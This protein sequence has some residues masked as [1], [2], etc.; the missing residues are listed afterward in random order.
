MRSSFCSLCGAV[1]DSSQELDLHCPCGGALIRRCLFCGEESQASLKVCLSC[2]TPFGGAPLGPLPP[3][4]YY[5]GPYLCPRCGVGNDI[6]ASYCSSCG[7]SLFDSGFRSYARRMALG[8]AATCRQRLAAGVADLMVLV[9][10]RAMLAVGLPS[11]SFE[12]AFFDRGVDPFLDGLFLAF[13]G[14]YLTLLPVLF[15]ATLGKRLFG[16]RLV[17]RDGSPVGPA[18]SFLRTLLLAACWVPLGLGWWPVAFSA[19]KRGLHDLLCDTLVVQ[20]R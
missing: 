4:V 20:R 18:R 5:G 3:P 14:I 8:P 17:C 16:L 2:G 19:S 1:P 10:A 9:V 6:A 11:A 7:G 15:G 12:W 13:S